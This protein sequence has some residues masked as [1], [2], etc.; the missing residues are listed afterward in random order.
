MVVVDV[1]VVVTVAV[2]VAD[3]NH[4]TTATAFCGYRG[5]KVPRIHLAGGWRGAYT[6][7]DF[8]PIAKTA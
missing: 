5:I 6:P 4:A 7:S 3:G 2:A 8:E 1:V